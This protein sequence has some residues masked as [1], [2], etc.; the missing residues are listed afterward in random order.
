[1]KTSRRQFLVGCSAAIAAL[2]GSRLRSLAVGSPSH[3]SDVLVVVFLRGGMDGLSL[4][5][6]LAGED[7]VY[8]EQARPTLR[9]PTSGAGAALPLNT[10]FGLHPA[11][12]PLHNL[13]QAG[14]LAIVQAVGNAGSR[15]HFDAQ[16]YI[17]LGTPG[18]SSTP[19]GWLTRAVDNS[20]LANDILM[21]ALATGAATPTSLQGSDQTMN[22]DSTDSFSLSRIG[23]WTWVQGEQQIALRRIYTAGDT[24][25]HDAGVQ[26]LNAVG[27]IESYVTPK[28]QSSGKIAYPETEF[29]NH[30]KMI[31]QI[32]K[33]DVGL[34][35]A[36]I[37]LGGWDTHQNQGVQLQGYFSN[38]VREL[39]SGL[40]ALYSDL[41]Y[42][43]SGSLARRLTIVAQSEFGR[44]IRENANRGTDHGTA[45]PILVLGGNVRGGLFG[46][47]PGLHPDQRFDGADLAATTDYRQIM[48]EILIRRLGNPHLGQIFPKFEPYQPLNLVAG[49]DLAPDLSVPTPDAPANLV[50]VLAEAGMVRLNWTRVAYASNYRIERRTQSDAAWLLVAT[51]GADRNSFDDLTVPSGES[52]SYRLQA[53]S[54]YG[55]SPFTSP[56]A[57]AAKTAIEQW[58]LRYFGSTDNSGPAADTHIS[59]EDGLSNFTKY[60]LGLDP[61]VPAFKRTIG[62]QPGRP[63]TEYTSAGLS[64]VYVRPTNRKDVRYQVLASDGLDQWTPIPE[65]SE[66][67]ADGMER[68][69]ATAPQGGAKM[70][71]LRLTVEPIGL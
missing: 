46:T 66:G 50:A 3:N 15:S 53:F 34:R 5:P 54:S 6:P 13:F 37:D 48:S 47:W 27:L 7:R 49:P 65:K 57:P 25:L 60:A 40:A 32:I 36:T 19:T 56:V 20:G 55:E 38:L 59:S 68:C 28:Y 9:I 23:H 21:P 10:Q 45:N 67:I 1:M 31:A 63:R 8:Y 26:A 29:G 4:V 71:F 58:R 2:A 12:A 11:A 39:S 22:M 14:K 44:R 61:L 70:K 35:V 42:T 51:L 43:N 16:R 18:N 62:F 41:E 17:E 30:L 64:L 52:V 24:F 33:L 69:R